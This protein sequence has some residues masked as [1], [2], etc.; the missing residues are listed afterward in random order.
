MNICVHTTKFLA[1][2]HPR[3]HAVNF[4]FMKYGICTEAM[5]VLIR[6]SLLEKS[7]IGIRLPN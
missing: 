6:S 2:L 4:L 5:Q 3:C 7:E 1:Y